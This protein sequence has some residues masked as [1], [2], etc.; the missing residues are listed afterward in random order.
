M[1]RSSSAAN[2]GRTPPTLLHW[3]FN[4]VLHRQAS[5]ALFDPTGDVT[6]ADLLSKACSAADYL[7]EHGLI[8]GK[9]VCFALTPSSE[10]V[11]WLLG[12]LLAG[13]VAA[14]VN[15][16]L[17]AVEV[18]TYT[19]R[20]NPGL[21]VCDLPDASLCAEVGS[22]IL[23]VP[24][25]PLAA[26]P[27]DVVRTRLDEYLQSIA[28]TDP[29]IVFPTGG[30]TGLPKGAYTDHEGLF[31]W[32]WNVAFGARR[33]AGEVEL[34]Y[35]PFFHVSLMV[36]LVGGIF[37]GGTVCIE[38]KFD[39][40]RA[41]R[42]IRERGITRLQG[43]PTMY[44]ALMDHPDASAGVFELVTDVIFGSTSATA[45]FVDRLMRTFPNAR[46]ATAYGATEFASGVTR[47]EHADLV[48]GRIV[49]VGRPNVGCHI[50]VIDS[51]GNDLPPGEVGQIIA[52]SP[53]QTLGYWNQPE[54][55]ES[56]YRPDGYIA[57]GDLG[58]FDEEGWLTIAGR[59]KEMIITGG[60][61]VF[62]VEVEQVLSS[63]AGVS[64]VVVFGVRDQ[65][66]G[67][68]VEA[69]VK[70]QSGVT[71]DV[72]ELRMLTRESLGGYKVPK[73][74]HLVVEIPMTSNNKPDRR[75]L[76]EMYETHREG[77]LAAD[78]ADV[79]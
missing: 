38:P 11:A 74:I 53:W 34:F 42:L 76:R 1:T 35:S 79:D 70:P 7:S 60:E 48:A 62:P 15:T 72:E 23:R 2:K 78:S 26:D 59:S 28:P 58:S 43:A 47:V 5:T 50:R 67:E 49:G 52:R 20:L 27:L 41:I 13:G 57:L 36:G 14:P 64:D 73:Q 18:A 30:T 33:H 66:W 29:A 9:P 63:L 21:V 37:A 39:P 69:V 65:T 40:G 19:S 44:Y 6:Y 10:Y 61:N 3:L 8:R 56:T 22:P 31:R 4:I 45:S 71:L 32:A 12:S 75:L 51:D 16:R 25:D 68:R 55:S 54:E 24:D 46:I 17:S 77:S